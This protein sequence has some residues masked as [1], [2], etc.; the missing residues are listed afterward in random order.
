MCTLI[1]VSLY[2]SAKSCTHFDSPFKTV[3]FHR[4]IVQLLFDVFVL[5]LGNRSA[6]IKRTRGGILLTATV[7]LYL[8]LRSIHMG[9]KFKQEI[10]ID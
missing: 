7:T 3:H 6:C 2:W 5:N 9:V 8:R 10:C 1:L 4:W